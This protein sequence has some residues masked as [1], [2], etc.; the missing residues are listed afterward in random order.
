MPYY[1][2][3]EAED[4]AGWAVVKE[5]MEI[6]GCHLM[7]QDA[8][9]QMVAISQEEGIEPGGELVEA[10]ELEDALVVKPENTEDIEM[11]AAPVKLTAQVTIDAAAPD[12]TPRRT[13]SG[14][15]E[16]G[17]AVSLRRSHRAAS[18]APTV[19]PPPSVISAG[20]SPA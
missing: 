18:A 14:I 16:S 1:I 4:C 5:D 3:K 15:T 17:V 12:G 2:T 20:T 8:I 19:V 7:K 10:E 11:S 6:L 13:I 9:D